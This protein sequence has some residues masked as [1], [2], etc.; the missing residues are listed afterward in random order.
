MAYLRYESEAIHYAM[1][2]GLF[3]IRATSKS[4]KLMNPEN[5]Q[6]KVF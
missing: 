1:N 6:P 3:V 4:A 2:Q 5:F